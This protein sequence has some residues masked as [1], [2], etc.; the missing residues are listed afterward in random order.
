M[1][2]VTAIVHETEYSLQRTCSGTCFRCLPKQYTRRSR[3]AARAGG[4]GQPSPPKKRRTSDFRQVLVECD[5]LKRRRKWSRDLRTR[6]T[7]GQQLLTTP[8]WSIADHLPGSSLA[9]R[10]FSGALTLP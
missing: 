3:S 4:D 2:R 8:P 1:L 7:G 6:P 9:T 5:R 10:G